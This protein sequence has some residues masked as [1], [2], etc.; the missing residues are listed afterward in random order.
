MIAALIVAVPYAATAQTGEAG[1]RLGAEDQ[2][3]VQ[4]YGTGGVTV[5][6]RIKSDGSITLPLVGRVQAADQTT[7]ALAANITAALKRGDVIRDPI[8]NVEIATYASRMVTMLGEFGSPGLLPLDRPLSLTEMVA[9]VGGLRNG[10][11]DTVLLRHAS[12]STEQHNLAAI[13]KG[14]ARDVA[15][16]SGDAVYAMGAPQYYI[17]GQIGNAGL[18]AI[19]PQMTV[20]QALARAGGPTLAGSERKITLYRDGKE[21]DAELTA[22]VQPNDVLF[23]RERVF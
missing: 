17:Y 8:V 2:I 18:Y 22:L 20:R 16:Q 13:A 9:R 6:T 14:E 3:E 11:S 4:I 5:R 1:Y 21:Q 15:L 19:L 23:V 7:Q 12:G 10:A